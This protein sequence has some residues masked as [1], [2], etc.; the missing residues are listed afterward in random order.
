MSA[1]DES[2]FGDV[3]YAYTRAQALADGFLVDLTSAARGKG[4]CI[5]VACTIGVWSECVG[6]GTVSPRAMFELRVL[7][8]L[9]ACFRAARA[10]RDG[11]DRITFTVETARGPVECWALCGPGDNAE[12]VITIMLQGED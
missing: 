7:L 4:F 12:P 1:H 9:Q 11:D 5:P 3:V 6:Q 10:S 8:L 2:L